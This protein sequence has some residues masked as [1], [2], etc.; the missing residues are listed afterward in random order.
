MS[1]TS[2][3]GLQR[4]WVNGMPYTSSQAADSCSQRLIMRESIVW[5]ILLLL[6]RDGTGGARLWTK[7]CVQTW[8]RAAS[9]LRSQHALPCGYG[10]A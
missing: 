2:R 7:L 4:S 5:H 9:L 10:G 3:E 8:K 1:D 6:D